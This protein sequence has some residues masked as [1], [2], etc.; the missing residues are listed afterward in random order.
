MPNL[1]ETLDAERQRQEVS[2]NLLA[3]QSGLSPGRVHAI[4]KG[5]TP[6]PGIL[7]VQRLTAVLGKSLGWL[8]REMNRTD[9]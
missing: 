8:E 6:N 3:R 9:Q 1:A 7:T 2:V 5:G 4:L